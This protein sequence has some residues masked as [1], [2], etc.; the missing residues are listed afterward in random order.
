L[1]VVVVVV[2]VVVGLLVVC[3]AEEELVPLPPHPA[4]APLLA[5]IASVVSMA[6]RGVFLIGRLQSQ[7]FGVS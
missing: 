2:V 7:L 6:F 5:R 1:C 3:V 4:T